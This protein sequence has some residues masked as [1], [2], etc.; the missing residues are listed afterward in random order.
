MKIHPDC[1]PCLIKQME[2]TAK[3]AGASEDTI[4]KVAATVFSELDRIWDDNLSPPAVSKPLYHL[5]G[6][7]CGVED[8]FLDMK[9]RY[10]REALKLLPELESHV[11]K[12]RDPFDTAVRV[13]IAG[14]IIDFGTGI[15]GEDFDLEETLASFL[16]KQLF[17]DN[18]PEMRRRVSDARTVLYIGD[19]AGETVFDRP[20]LKL[21]AS[22]E[23]AYAAKEGAIINDATV[24]DAA[25]AGVHLHAK[26]MSS[27][28]SSPGT[29]LEDCSVRFRDVF[30]RADVIIAKG[31]GN[32]ETLTELTQDG[33]IFMLFTVKCPV[34]AQHLG[35]TMGDMVVKQW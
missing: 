10:T 9:V 7:M 20:L 6:R 23:V 12:S 27:G 17:T 15:H 25:L 1:R 5:T 33:R 14:N 2:T 22:A 31:Q 30:D 34:A 13:S 18:I 21:L 35:A 16:E 29:I 8:P 4:R 26:L 11:H 24:S 19:N 3:A 28:S 32:F